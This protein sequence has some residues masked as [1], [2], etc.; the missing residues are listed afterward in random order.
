MSFE[1]WVKNNW[2]ERRDSDREEIS[3]LLAVADGCLEDYRK[4]V[5]GEL[6]SDVQL[7]LAYDAIRACATAALRATGYRVVRGG[8]EH[9]RTIETLEFSI[10]PERKL[11]PALASAENA[12]WVPTTI[13]VSYRREKQTTA[14]SW[15]QGFES[16]S[17]S[18]FARTTPTRSKENCTGLLEQRAFEL[19]R[20]R[21][22]RCGSGG[23]PAFQA[24]YGLGHK[25]V[26]V[27][28]LRQK[29][30]DEL[31]RRNYSQNT[32]CT[33]MHAVEEFSRYF[34]RSPDKLGPDHIRQY[35]AYL[36]RERKLQAG[37]IT[38][39]TAALRFL[40]VKTLRRQILD[41]LLYRL[42]EIVLRN[43]VTSARGLCQM[44]QHAFS[45][46]AVGRPARRIRSGYR[47]VSGNCNER[48]RRISTRLR[49]FFWRLLGRHF[50]EGTELDGRAAGDASFPAP[51]N[52]FFHVGAVEDPEAADVLLGF[53]ERAVSVT[54]VLDRPS[55]SPT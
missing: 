55:I 35:Q 32:I 2:L 7:G 21:G 34:H 42:R 24:V 45:C 9:Y 19:S 51:P 38:C 13:T 39:C 47:M 12:T 18:G 20:W 11:I 6:S 3:C 30:L 17:R 14:A 23:P 10:D 46:F 31:Q 16:R 22:R 44:T 28:H 52:G 8:S 49:R 37:T 40:Y 50:K 27:T 29:M 43:D 33:Y 53:E 48:R 25:E 15:L 5:E 1:N 4:A 41:H 36:F 26:I 54:A